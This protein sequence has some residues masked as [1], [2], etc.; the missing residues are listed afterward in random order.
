MQ[1]ITK[2]QFLLRQPSY[3]KVMTTDE[4]YYNLANTLLEKAEKETLFPGWPESVVQRAALA[5]IGYYQDVIA[6]SGP[7][8]AFTDECR[9]LYGKKLPFYDIG[10]DYIDYELNREDVRFMVWYAMTMNY[11]VKRLTSPLDSELLKGADVWYELLQDE[12]DEAPMP[13][14]HTPALGLEMRDPEDKKAIYDYGAW[15]FMH[16]YLMTPAFAL[17]LSELLEGIDLTKSD[18]ITEINNRLDKALMES[19]TGP[20]ALYVIEWLHLIIEKKPLPEPP[21]EE[22][23][24]EHPYYAGFV[25]ATNGEILKFFDS[26]EELNKF[27]IEALGWDSKEEHLAQLKGAHDFVLMVNKHK[28]MLLARNVARCL[29]APMNPYYDEAYAREHAIEL[30]T[31]RGL[32]PADLLRHALVNGWIPDARFPGSDDTKLVADN[33]D[34]IARCYLQ[35]YYRGD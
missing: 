15:L 12:Y 10:P 7:W 18:N 31:V 8:H 29:K 21:E 33:S 16:C 30:L 25:K 11:D 3:P 13:E 1:K 5:V 28:G 35:T 23:S 17:T 26:Y 34:F 4:Y 6:D 2:Q 14:G 19:P 22:N 24:E 32:C 27:F 9:R 20:L